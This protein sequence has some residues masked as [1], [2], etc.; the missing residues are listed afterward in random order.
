MINVICVKHGEKYDHEY[1]NRLYNMVARHLSLDHEFYCFTDDSSSINQNIN[2]I[3]I[4]PK[5]GIAGWW[6]K[7]YIFA[8]EHFCSSGINLYFDLDTVIVGSIDHFVRYEPSKFVGLRDLA[9]V[10]RKNWIRLGS[11]VMKW[12]TGTYTDIWEKFKSDKNHITK[13]F[14]GD[15]DW[16]WHLHRKSI[17][18]FP[19]KWIQSYKWQIRQRDELEKTTQ[20]LRFKNVRNPQI[21]PDTSVLAFHGSPDVKDV[22]DPVIV[23]HWR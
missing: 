7:P 1:V 12:P 18:F 17:H 14:R 11:A 16:I 6:C 22:K 8:S 13:K 4:P 5:L 21:P 15:Q 10:F 19:E 20:G 9:K 2:V 3:D 23:K